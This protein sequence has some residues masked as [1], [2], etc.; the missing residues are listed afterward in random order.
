MKANIRNKIMKWWVN[1]DGKIIDKKKWAIQDK[2]GD[3]WLISGS[4]FPEK[5]GQ[6]KEHEVN[7]GGPPDFNFKKFFYQILLASLI[8]VSVALNIFFIIIHTIR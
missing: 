8:G 2:S 7:C 4:E 6:H 1:K 3:W 5:K